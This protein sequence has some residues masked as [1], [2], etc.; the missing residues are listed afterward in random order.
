[1]AGET[2]QKRYFIRRQKAESIDL[3]LKT[4]E[5]SLDVEL[6]AVSLRIPLVQLIKSLDSYEAKHNIPQSV[7]TV[8]D[9][10]G[11]RKIRLVIDRITGR[12]KGDSTWLDH[13]D[14]KVLLSSSK[15]EERL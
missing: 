8:E 1:M 7:M 6:N 14:A 11:S 12:F 10:I 5:L 15:N 9:S 3:S 4:S 13:L 2:E